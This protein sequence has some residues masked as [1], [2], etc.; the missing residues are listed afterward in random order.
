[1]HTEIERKFLVT[2]SD[3]IAKLITYNKYES[4]RITQGYVGNATKGETRVTIRGDKAYMGFK[5]TNTFDRF[6]FMQPIELGE[7]RLLQDKV[8][9]SF[10]SKL[11]YLIPYGDLTIELDIFDGANKGLIIAEI[12]LPYEDYDLEIPE[13]FG[14]EVTNDPMYHNAFLAQHPY[15]EN[16]IIDIHD[17]AELKRVTEFITEGKSD[18]VSTYDS[19]LREYR[20]DIG[21]W[22]Y[23]L[24]DISDIYFT[25]SGVSICGFDRYGDEAHFYIPRSWFKDKEKYLKTHFEYMETNRKAELQKQIKAKE[26]EL[27]SLKKKLD[28][29]N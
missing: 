7:A 2:N 29:S 25:V 10:I 13:W 4:I 6:E 27:N 21:A 11:R 22:F 14:I 20:K 9:D 5:T 23:E 3:F 15:S 17:F 19:L 24:S 26:E 16:H 12:E 1:M 28:A 18:L 8:C